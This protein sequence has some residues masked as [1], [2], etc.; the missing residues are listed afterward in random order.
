MF[1]S[2][3]S[4]RY[5]PGLWLLLAGL[6]FSALLGGFG[7]NH[8]RSARPIAEGTLRGLA[9]TLASTIEALANQD[10]SLDLL[11]RVN[12]SDIA[13]YSVFDESGTQIFHTN[14][15]LI[16]SPVAFPF[17]P[18]DFAGYVFRERRITLGTG[19]KVFEFLTP[20]HVAGTSF[21]LR[22]VLHTYQADSVVR[23]EQTA[24]A[25][26]C[27]LLTAGWAMGGLLYLY[28]RRAARHRREMAEQNHLAQL[29]T[30]SAVLAHEVRNP[31]SGIKGY[32][33]LLEESI[34]R[35]QERGFANQVVTEAVR[36][37]ELVTDL[38]VY[39][40]PA[41]VKV[42]SVGLREAVERVF[43]LLAKQVAE[44]E[45]RL[46]CEPDGWTR[47][48]ADADR[49]QQILLNLLLN[50]VQAT[51]PEGMVRVSARRRG[52]RVE[53]FIKDSG[54]GIDPEDLSR[55][56]EPFF[57]RR[58]RGTGL[59]L[60]I[61]K[62]FVEEMGGTITVSSVLGEGSVFTLGLSVAEKG[63]RSGM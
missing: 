34:D 59:G 25:V 42:E 40:Q 13:F 17:T 10:A 49:L 54:R 48:R 39:A 47:V 3:I 29:G 32:A 43:A 16:G 37:E 45:V 30:L 15:E 38:L 60:A 5:A 6:L 20:V 46:V 14:P 36:L 4:R 12:S 18:P 57:T 1:E 7:L 9:L 52:R 27:G 24:L 53:L 58:A 61:C 62:K 55:I 41:A 44:G 50:A 22:L 31:L 35:E 28:A 33:Q 26:L 51:P 56:F 2:V 19:E 21:V 63:A 8:Y 11:R 23:R